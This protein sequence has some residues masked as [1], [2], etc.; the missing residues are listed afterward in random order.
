MNEINDEIGA[1]GERKMPLH[2]SDVRAKIMFG[3]ISISRYIMFRPISVS[4]LSD[5]NCQLSAVLLFG[6]DMH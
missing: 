2:R 5:M 6:Y 1:A 4:H 3:P